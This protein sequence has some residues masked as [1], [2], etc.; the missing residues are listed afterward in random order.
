MTVDKD[1]RCHIFS[2][3]VLYTERVGAPELPYFK[4]VYF[5]PYN[6]GDFKLN[7]TERDSHV[8][9]EDYTPYP[10]QGPQKVK[11]TWTTSRRL[12]ADCAQ[13]KSAVP[14]ADRAE[15]TLKETGHV[16]ERT[17]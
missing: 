15:H 8:I 14:T 2:E 10:S 13:A 6:L 1:G 12:P 3:G 9:I 17:D 16:Y 11:S 5:L 7:V 4:R